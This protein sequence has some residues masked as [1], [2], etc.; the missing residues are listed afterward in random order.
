MLDTS[1]SCRGGI[2]VSALFCSSK[3]PRSHIIAVGM[4]TFISAP[5]TSP[6]ITA[7]VMR[8]LYSSWHSSCGL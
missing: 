2:P 1:S 3:G 8:L 5:G 7:E 4:G 6:H